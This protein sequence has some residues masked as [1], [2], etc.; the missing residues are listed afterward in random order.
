MFGN[1]GL[2][3]TY[4]KQS[5]KT[6]TTSSTLTHTGSTVGSLDGNVTLVAGNTLAITGS[7][8]MAL[9]GDITAKAKDI[10]ITEVHDTRDSTQKTAFKQGGLTM[11][12]TS[13]A[14]NLAQGAVHSAQAGSQAKGDARMQAL[15][16]ASAAYSA[17]GAGQAMGKL[18]SAD[19]AK[20][21]MQGAG[22]NVAITVGGSRSHSESTQHS[23]TSKG[24]TLHAGGNVTLIA[25]GGGDDSNLLIRGSD[26]KAGNNLLL[27]AD[28]DITVESAQDS[29][30]QHSRSK[31]GSAAIGAAISYGAKGAAMGFT[32]NASTAH[33]Q[34]DGTDVTQRNSHLSAGNTATILSGNDTTL[35]GAVLSANTVMA[36]VGGDLHIHSEQDTSH[37]ASHDTAASA[38]VTVGIGAS[39]SAS[40]SHS[41]VDGDFASVR[42]QS[43]IQAGDGGFDI[44][45]HGNTDLKGAVIAST[46][47]AIDQGRNQLTTGT[48]TVAD[49]T[50]TSHYKATG[51]NLSG[52]YAAGGSNGKSDGKSDGS[53]GDTASSQ[54]PPTANQGSS[55]SWQNQ[56][57]GARGTAAGYDSKSGSQ[58]SITHSGISGGD[59]TITDAAGQQAKSGKSIADTLAAL[60]RDVHTGDSGNGLVKDWNGQQLQQQVTAGA[61]IMATFGQQASKAIGDYASQKALELRAQGNEAEAAKW[62]EGG[63]YRVAAHAAMGALGGGVQGALGAGAAASAAPRLNEL[64]KDL[65]DGVREAVGAGLAAGLGSVTGGASGAAT[66]FNEDTNNRQLHPDEIKKINENAANFAA[67]QCG[68]SCTPEQVEAARQRL[69]I[70]AMRQTDSRWNEILGM[71]GQVAQD[72]PALSFL[73]SINQTNRTYTDFAAD[74]GQYNDHSMFADTLRGTTA[75]NQVYGAVLNKAVSNDDGRFLLQALNRTSSGWASD[76]VGGVMSRDAWIGATTFSGDVGFAADVTKKLVNGNINGALD[77]VAGAVILSKFGEIGGDV[78]GKAIKSIKETL[79]SSGYTLGF[80]TKE[81]RAGAADAQVFKYGGGFYSGSALVDAESGGFSMYDQFKKP[82]GS[83]WDWPENLGFAGERVETTL[84]VG[85]KLDRYG[86]PEGRFLSPNGV[87]YEQRALAPGSRS[88]GYYE[89]EVIEPLPVIQGKI[90]PA[91][92]QPGGGVQILPRF[93]YRVD[94]QWLL[95][96]EFLKRV[97]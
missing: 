95:D 16:G 33:G 28:H 42:E 45:V 3:V 37:Y 77:S 68:D 81:M 18:L 70:Q 21:A 11:S 6:D 53:S 38:S 62:D 29:S 5:L 4:G 7:D 93:P 43:G 49:I 59:L 97:N 84:S 9:Q 87:P 17:Y 40:Y 41:K 44:T 50:N 24:S 51:V 30:E 52:G 55:W 60:N 35:D 86:D 83:A 26:V 75:L 8:V 91:F 14:L 13:A 79:N 66:A 69:I 32:A 67:L 12:V 10:A 80:V 88:G 78:A 72:G 58:T 1:G 48:L 61:E 64:T 23:D 47:A 71:G 39:G 92:G 46:Q 73:D 15:A 31:S 65:P 27:A 82:D 2:S 85:T 36:D 34:G 89:Y 63:A 20:D 54:M 56:G 74:W 57:S 96:N 94:V 22:I 19:S 76:Y 90:A 25:T